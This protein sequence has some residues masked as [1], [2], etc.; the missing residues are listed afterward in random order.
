[1]A[2]LKK[3]EMPENIINHTLLVNKIAIFLAE[4][5]AD[6][7]EEIFVPLIDSGSL[8]HDIGKI[9]SIKAKEMTGN[10]IAEGYEILQKENL[11]SEAIICRKHGALSPLNPITKPKS[12]EEKV[13]FY[14][15]KR[16]IHDKI[17]SLKERYDDL[18]KRYPKNSKELD[19]AYSFAEKLEKEIFDLIEIK[20]DNLK[21]YIK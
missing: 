8:L 10:H 7:G 4:K 3:Y 20:S 13:V 15:D 12:W 5:L 11:I 14:A 9:K 6:K 1:M 21:N 16:V 18:K 17:G 2:L 19:K